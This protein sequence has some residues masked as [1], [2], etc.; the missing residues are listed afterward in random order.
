MRVHADRDPREL[1]R[2]PQAR[3]G[4]FPVPTSHVPRV[5]RDPARRVGDERLQLA[6]DAGPL[7]PV[8]L[9]LPAAA[10]QRRIVG[11]TGRGR[12]L[13]AALVGDVR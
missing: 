3:P 12:A 5:G 10:P 13:A 11:S 8:D 1:P 6:Q 2:E 4:R 7:D 9:V